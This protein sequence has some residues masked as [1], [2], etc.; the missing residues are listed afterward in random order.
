MSAL[1]SIGIDSFEI[2][3][4][5]VKGIAIGVNKDNRLNQNTFFILGQLLLF[6]YSYSCLLSSFRSCFM[7]RASSHFSNIC[8]QTSNPTTTAATITTTTTC[9]AKTQIVHFRVKRIQA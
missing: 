4:E 5:L 9:S 3:L 7:K 2:V 8:I 6:L 1:V